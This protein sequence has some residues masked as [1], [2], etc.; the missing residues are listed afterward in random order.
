VPSWGPI[1]G[2]YYLGFAPIAVIVDGVGYR[3]AVR[4][5]A[6]AARLPGGGH[7]PLV[8]GYFAFCLFLYSSTP[9]SVVSPATPSI[10]TWSFA[11]LS[12]YLHV[13]MLGALTYRWM[14]VRERAAEVPA[15]GERRRFM[16]R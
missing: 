7:L 11:L 8:F 1:V 5:S 4:R 3:E 6:R 9:A 14:A 10:L 15:P 12:T 13:G 16:E 2:L